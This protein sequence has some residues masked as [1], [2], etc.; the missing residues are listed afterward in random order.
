MPRRP[1]RL[2]AIVE[3][4]EDAIV[5]KPLD[6]VIRTWN[7]GAERLFGYPAAEA[8]GRPIAL[9]IPPNGSARNE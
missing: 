9:I 2:A 5:S 4:S 1:A 7:A 3:S 8:L 6:G